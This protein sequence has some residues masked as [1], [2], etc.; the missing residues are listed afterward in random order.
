MSY[1]EPY[2]KVGSLSQ[3]NSAGKIENHQNKLV[4]KNQKR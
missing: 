2:F 4:A 3:L 1:E